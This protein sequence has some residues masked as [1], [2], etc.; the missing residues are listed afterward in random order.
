MSRYQEEYYRQALAD[1]HARDALGEVRRTAILYAG[2]AI[3]LFELFVIAYML[4]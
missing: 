1:Q 4:L 3:V 2:I